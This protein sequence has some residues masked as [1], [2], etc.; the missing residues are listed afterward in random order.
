MEGG[1]SKSPLPLRPLKF[2]PIIKEH[3]MPEERIYLLIMK[4]MPISHIENHI[5]TQ[6]THIQT[7]NGERI[8]LA[9]VGTIEEAS[10]IHF[11]SLINFYL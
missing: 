11:K 2:Q 5:T 8:N 7:T 6:I 1:G 10:K 3:K 9:S 4:I